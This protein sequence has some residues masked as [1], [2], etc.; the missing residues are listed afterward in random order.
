MSTDKPDK[1]KAEHFVSDV[2]RHQQEQEKTYRSR[3]LSMY[4]H[5]CGRCGREFSG[6]KLR[7]LTVHHR[8]H[9]HDNNPTDGSN[10]ELLCLYCHENEHARNAVADAYEGDNSSESPKST[11]SQNPFSSLGDLLKAKK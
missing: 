11:L 8:D 10:W 7:E 4:P 5:I 2:R 1:T 9:N 3:A 6:K